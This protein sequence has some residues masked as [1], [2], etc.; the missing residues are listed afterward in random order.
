[1]TSRASR[2]S[3]SVPMTK[4]V[5]TMRLETAKQLRTILEEWLVKTDQSQNLPQVESKVREIEEAIYFTTIRNMVQTIDAQFHKIYKAFASNLIFNLTEYHYQHLLIARIWNDT[6]ATLN[7]SIT[8]GPLELNR[9]LSEIQDIQRQEEKEQE[10]SLGLPANAANLQCPYC[11][12][13]KIHGFERQ[14][15]GSDEG[16][17]PFYI[18]LNPDCKK[19]GMEQRRM[20]RIKE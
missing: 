15:R 10:R 2:A 13:T 18:C 19:Y 6:I 3:A 20:R 8:G 12:G 5:P 1:M 17:T 14:T 9:E 7:S 11:N 16:G 4:T